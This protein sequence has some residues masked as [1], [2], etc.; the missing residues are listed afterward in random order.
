LT[1]EATTKDVMG[2]NVSGFDFIYIP[3]RLL[4]VVLFI[5]ELGMRIPIRRKYTSMA[6]FFECLTKPAYPAK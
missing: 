5:D 6:S 3:K 1:W 2:W 4:P